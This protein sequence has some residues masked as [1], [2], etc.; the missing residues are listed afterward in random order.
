MGRKARNRIELVCWL[1]IAADLLVVFTSRPQIPSGAQ[2]SIRP[3]YTPPVVKPVTVEAKPQSCRPV[4]QEIVAIARE[5][6]EQ[7]VPT[8]GPSFSAIDRCVKREQRIDTSGCPANFRNAERRFVDAQQTLCRDA[9]DDYISDPLVV[10]RA[11]FDVYQH[12][13]PYDSLDLMSD[14]I[15]RDLDVFQSATFDLIQV[16]ETYGVN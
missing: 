16:S 4:I 13:S 1:G 15:R 8:H 3:S 12:R 14:V 2:A 7:T 11:F 10:Q 9:H 5:E 6:S